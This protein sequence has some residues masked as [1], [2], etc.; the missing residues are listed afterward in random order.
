MSNRQCGGNI[1][2]RQK[3]TTRVALLLTV[4][5]ALTACGGDSQAPDPVVEDFGIAYLKR[6]LSLNGNP[7][8]IDSDV[9]R[10]LDFNAGA[11]LYV[12]ERAGPTA[13]ERNVTRR[14]TG[15]LGGAR[16]VEVSYDGG[17]LLFAMR[18]AEIE[19][20]DPEDQPTWNIW[21]Y[22]VAD[23][24]LRRIIS[25]D[26]T[27]EAGHDVAPHYLPDGRIV[28]SST[29]Q[30]QSG[31]ILLDEGKPQYPAF[32]EGGNE[33]ALVLHV[34]N[35]DGSEIRQISFNQSHDLDPSVLSSGEIV[36]TRWDQAARRNEMSL[37]KIRPDG[38]ELQLLYGAHS[39]N[40]GTDNSVVQF[41]A[42]REMPDG[43]MMTM[44]RPFDGTN[45]GGNIIIIDTPNY[46]DNDQPTQVNQGTLSGPAQTAATINDVRSDEI[47]ALGGRFRSFFPLWDGTNRILVS[48][49]QCRLMENGTIV[50]C[51]AARLADANAVEAPPLYGIF[52]YNI[53]DETQRPVVVPEEGMI[54]SDV[55]A[56]QPRTA[57]PVLFDKQG[58]VELDE[59]FVTEGVGVLHIR[60][61]YDMDGV[62]SANPDI[63]TLA[64]PGQTTADQRPARFLRIVKTVSM[65]DRDLLNLPGSAFGRDRNQTMKE[66]IGYAPIEPDGSVMVKVPADVALAISVLDQNGRRTSARHQ[67]WIQVRPGEVKTC[68]GCHDHNSGIPHGRPEGPASI[69]F[70][71]PTG[72]TAFVNTEPTMVAQMGETMAETRM[73]IS[74]ETDCAALLPSVDLVYD[75]VWTDASVRPKDPSF[76]YRYADLT[77]TPPVTSKCL[78]NWTSLCRTVISY[79]AHIH[80]LWAEPRQVLDANDV[81]IADNTCTTCHGTLDAMSQPQVPAAQLDLSDGPSSDEPDQFKAYRELLF[82]DNELE[83]VNGVLQERLVQATDGAGNLLF[84]VDE[85][86]VQILDANDAPIPIMVPVRAI[87]P[88]MSAAGA[89]SSYFLNLFDADGSHFGRLSE[90]EKR[91][92][93][94]WLDVGAQYYNNPFDVPLQN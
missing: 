62:D 52:I 93:A 14:F 38:S 88:S 72:G 21:E 76:A 83:L 63:V 86:G 25:S 55:V 65:P 32:E 64:D 49:S 85:N 24:T 91:L 34:M 26:N 35:D 89:G 84:E 18:A 15:G 37:Y 44:L 42:P 4:A 50:P 23:D 81:V 70:G 82:A 2:M 33:P 3:I 48:W 9:R 29:R 92:I 30:R 61:V 12:R 41:L 59:D 45:G 8:P 46:I 75:D 1:I 47:P 19:G 7:N 16:D 53:D 22:V 28:F 58:G 74:C 68:N 69:N 67:Y 31:A 56:M 36:F 77:T 20:A 51:T 78:S 17:K 87:G 80:P 90:A 54:I 57:P 43:R 11:D 66:I 94:E 6:P 60:S 27:A 79:E 10:Q 13:T 5:M 71:A 40:T 39:H 73:R